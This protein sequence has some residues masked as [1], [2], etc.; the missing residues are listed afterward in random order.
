MVVAPAADFFGVGASEDF[1]EVVH[2]HAE[3]AALANPINTREKLLGL[4]GG[5]VA[6]AGLEAVVAGVAVR[7]GVAFREILQKLAAA[8]A[9]TLGVVEHQPQ[10][11]AGHALLVVVRDFVDEMGLLGGVA[12]AEE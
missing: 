6:L 3:A 4:G 8:A 11:L 9:R 12:R 2:A 5:V 7:L 10:L 1:D